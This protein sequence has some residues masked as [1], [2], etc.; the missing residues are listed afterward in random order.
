LTTA[1][2]VAGDYDADG[3]AD[4]ADFLV[5]QRGGSPDP[6][7]PS[8]LAVWRGNFGAADLA[9]LGIA[10]PEPCASGI[11]LASAFLLPLAR[12]RGMQEIEH[13]A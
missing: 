10:T 4:G 5:W 11:I 2:T 9:A 12:R 8:D 6:V 3:D 1:A 7:S 13:R